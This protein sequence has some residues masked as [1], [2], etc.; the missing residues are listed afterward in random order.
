MD[1]V[2]LGFIGLGLRG[3]DWV[4][5]INS[6]D[7]AEVIFMCDIEDRKIEQAKER[8]EKEGRAIPKVTK[9]YKDIIADPEVEAVM[10]ASA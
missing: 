3:K 8:L 6:R 5:F 9:D 4:S 1:K 2:K 7:D 10:I